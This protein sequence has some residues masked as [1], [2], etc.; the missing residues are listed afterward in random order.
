MRRLIRRLVLSG[1]LALAGCSITATDEDGMAREERADVREPSEA[2][3]EVLS[4]ARRVATVIGHSVEGRPI[5]AR[6]VGRGGGPRVYLIG[7]IHGDEP[8]GV[9]YIETLTSRLADADATIR[10]LM[11]MNPDGEALN[12]RTNV[13]GVD[14]NRNWPTSNFEASRSHGDVPLSEPETNAAL[15]DME[16]FGPDL[17]VV[18][19]STSRGPFVNHDGPNGSRCA[20]IFAQA[21][22]RV[23]ASWTVVSDIGYPTPGSLGSWGI[24]QRLPILTIEFVR[25]M[26]AF[27]AMLAA[28]AGI[29]AVIRAWSS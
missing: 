8:E 5:V 23:D 26:D 4:G 11:S 19:H 14:L 3:S 15:D 16:A 21:A 6:T 29:D 10:V 18:F 25:G 2:P 9:A 28:E 12:R 22:R 13:R 24:E 27:D 17:V 7:L 1:A 20:L